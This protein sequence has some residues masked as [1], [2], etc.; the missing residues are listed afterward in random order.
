MNQK[1]ETPQDGRKLGQEYLFPSL[2]QDWDTSSLVR[3][4]T[5]CD[6][7]TY[8]DWDD[9]HIPTEMI[10]YAS[11][12]FE[13]VLSHQRE[14]SEPTKDNIRSWIASTIQ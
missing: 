8:T 6:A 2:R 4:K 3:T 1:Q 12:S 7:E 13:A 11:H 5:F 14:L 9:C 10:V